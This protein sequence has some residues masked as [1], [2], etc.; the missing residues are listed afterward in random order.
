MLDKKILML[1]DGMSSLMREPSY[2]ATGYTDAVVDE[3]VTE[4]YTFLRNPED[5]NTDVVI[6]R[7]IEYNAARD[8]LSKSAWDV[9][10]SPTVSE[11]STNVAGNDKTILKSGATI[12]TIDG[13]NFGAV[14][15]DLQ[16]HVYVP[17]RTRLGMLTPT[18]FSNMLR[19]EATITAVNGGDTQ[20][21]ASV[22]LA[23]Y[24]N[25]EVGSGT[26]LVEVLNKKRHLR[27]LFNR[28]L[29]LV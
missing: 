22:T 23:S 9:T 10:N 3:T 20:I 1:T 7:E 19:F 25:Q 15:D 21:T 4:S 27:S 2:V 26:V 17:Q 6:S 13:T 29:T 28:E 12:L 24:T 14:D 5:A 18:S 16:V 11:V 8:L